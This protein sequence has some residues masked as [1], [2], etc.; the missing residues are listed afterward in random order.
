M[1]LQWH[2]GVVKADHIV[3]ACGG[4]TWRVHGRKNKRWEA[5]LVELMQIDRDYMQFDRF[6]LDS[7]RE[8]IAVKLGV[9]VDEVCPIPPDLILA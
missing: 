8:A 5:H 3:V 2:L 6:L 1:K 9:A 4:Y 7:I